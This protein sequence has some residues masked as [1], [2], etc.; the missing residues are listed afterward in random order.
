MHCSHMEELISAAL[1]GELSPRRRKEL[2]DHLEHCPRCRALFEELSGQSQLLRDLDCRVPEDLSQQILSAL[3]Q[4][5]KKAPILSIR[6]WGT[7][8]ACLVLVCCAG[9][10]LRPAGNKSADAPSA[11]SEDYALRTADNAL[12]DAAP[13]ES[14]AV[15]VP[16]APEPE[17]AE[18]PQECKAD[19]LIRAVRHYRIDWT[20][21]LAN[22]AFAV[23]D[24]EEFAALRARYPEL[25]L[26]DTDLPGTNL[27]TAHFIAVTLTEGSGSVSHEVEDVC[28]TEGGCE[29]VIRREVPEAGTCDMAGWLILVEV[30]PVLSEKT[31]LT[32]TLLQ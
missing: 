25:L 27:N 3:P 4:Q 7:A 13:A 14:Q 5:R 30:E 20:E 21:E 2:D 16:S 6:R 26:P 31:D 19:S 15:E 11:A 17:D 24:D 23:T 1:D 8:A 9:F 28:L 29:V 12:K 32:L 18:K 22:E 10:A